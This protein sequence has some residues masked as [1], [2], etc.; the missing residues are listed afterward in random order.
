MGMSLFLTAAVWGWADISVTISPSNT[1]QTME[2]FG[3][4]ISESTAWLMQNKLSATQRSNLLYELFSTNNG[5]GLSALRVPIGASDFRLADYTLDDVS[6]GTTDYSLT[7]FSIARDQA[8]VI[9]LLR[10]IRTVSTNVALMATPWT[11]PA[12]MKNSTNLYYGRLNA[13]AYQVYAEYLLRF[14]QAYTATGLPIAA[15]TLQN[16]PLHQ[17]YSYPGAYMSTQQQI[18]L[19]PVVGRLFQSNAITT[20]ILC[21]D[22]NWDDF[23]YPNAVLSNATARQYLAGTAFHG[24]EGVVSN[25]SRVHLAHPDKDIYFTEMSSGIWAGD[26][27]SRLMWDAENLLVGATRHWAKTVI[28]WNLALDLAGGPKISG[29]CSGCQG[30]VTINTNSGA[31]TRMFDYYV[32]AHI[33]AFVRPGAVR[34]GCSDNAYGVPITVAFRNPDQSLAL[35]A[36]NKSST[37]Q[38]VTIRWNDQVTGFLLPSKSLASVGWP[39]TS[40]ATTTVRI[41]RGDQTALFQLLTN[42]P[43]FNAQTL[44]VSLQPD[45]VRTSGAQWRIDGGAWQSGTRTLPLNAGTHT[46]ECSTVAQWIE[47]SLLA[48][49]LASNQARF[50]ALT[51]SNWPATPNA[52]SFRTVA[53]TNS[54]VLSWNDPRLSRFTNQTVLVRFSTNGYPETTTEGSGLYTGALRRLTHENLTPLVTYYYTIWCTQDGLTFTNPP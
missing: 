49:S 39:D 26:F 17:P 34:I 20:K 16:E 1:Y 29:G 19:I 11:P 50:V 22:H 15:I 41:T 40:G 48:V 12:W 4:A 25:Q 7:Y 31:I 2:G 43:A 45:A 5:I 14:I 53:L 23:A 38:N 37:T 30:I 32:L 46:A 13:G 36:L 24:Y 27:S 42:P 44:I 3:A 51:Y 33:S 18:N 52:F 21:Y 8:W 28:K 6:A 9:P 47:P 35:I 54:I 10:Q